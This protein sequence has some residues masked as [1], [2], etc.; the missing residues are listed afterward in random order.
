MVAMLHRSESRVSK[1]VAHR[2]DLEPV[3]FFCLWITFSCCSRV[4]CSRFSRSQGAGIPFI[5]E[6]FAK[7]NHKIRIVEIGT[8]CRPW[9][10]VPI[11]TARISI[12]LSL[13]LPHERYTS[14]LGTLP[15]G[16][17]SLR[18]KYAGTMM[19]G[20]GERN[21]LLYAQTRLRAWWQCHLDKPSPIRATLAIFIHF[22]LITETIMGEI[23][24]YTYVFPSFY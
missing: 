20:G 24:K 14:P 6:Y 15:P 17:E 8:C 11:S 10:H 21:N 1:P 3:L 7:Q 23:N 9:Q 4:F 13:Y 12:L 2:F 22:G 5:R 18:T 16:N 19:N